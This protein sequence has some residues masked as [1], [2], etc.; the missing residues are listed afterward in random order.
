M[1]KAIA[2][3]AE[4]WAI[5]RGDRDLER[6]GDL[7]PLLYIMQEDAEKEV[8]PEDGE[9]VVPVEVLIKEREK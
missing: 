8:R 7:L 1:A 6:E 4:L 2:Y 3:T 5:K 9:E